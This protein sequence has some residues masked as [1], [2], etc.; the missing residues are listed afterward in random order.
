MLNLYMFV[1][2]M[3]LIVTF[4]NNLLLFVIFVQKKVIY[5]SFCFLFVCVLIEAGSC[6]FE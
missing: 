6:E 3:I 2:E 4:H 1:V 5:K